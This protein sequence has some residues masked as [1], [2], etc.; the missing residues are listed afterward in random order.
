MCAASSY[1]TDDL[2]IALS[3]G[4]IQVV[5]VTGGGTGIGRMIAQGF[6]DNGGWLGGSIEVYRARGVVVSCAESQNQESH[7]STTFFHQA[8]A[9][10]LPA[11]RRPA[12]PPPRSHAPRRIPTV[13]SKSNFRLS[14]WLC[15][16][17][18]GDG[19]D[20]VLVAGSGIGGCVCEKRIC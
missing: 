8:R 7:S 9:C 5:L 18:C 10:T 15:V 14:L 12:R 16:C 6:V 19:I 3:F 11:A 2:S 17:V 20:L 13:I 1:C 4:V